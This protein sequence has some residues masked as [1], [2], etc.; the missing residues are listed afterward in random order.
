M[1]LSVRVLFDNIIF[2]SKFIKSY[3]FTLA[4]RSFKYL[5]ADYKANFEFPAI[6]VS[7]NEDHYTFGERPNVIQN[8]THAN[9]N[10]I[11]VLYDP[12]TQ[13]TVLIQE[14]HIQATMSIVINCE[15]QFQA[16]ECEFAC[17]RNLPVGKHISLFDFTS[18]LDIPT[19]YLSTLGIDYNRSEVVNLYTRMN[20]NTGI[21]GHCFSLN[22]KP[23]VRLDSAISTMSDT[24]Q[25]SFP[26]NI[27][28]MYSVQIPVWATADKGAP[29]IE[30][31]NIDFSR[32]GHEPIS[33]NSVRPLINNNTDK[34]GDSKRVI[35]RNLIVH[36]LEDYELNIV[37]GQDGN[38]TY[39]FGITFT[40]EDFIISPSFMFNIF[41]TNGEILQDV[42]PSLIDDNLNKVVFSWKQDEYEQHYN[43]SLT[44]PI[45]VQF[46]EDR[47]E[48]IKERGEN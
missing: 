41:D 5:K 30:R 18:F 48:L 23:F 3:E 26:V 42:T 2:P 7:L 46:V 15:S 21:I 13:I 14:E 44:N 47:S 45:I 27:E 22:Y 4:N 31:I 25:R 38:N 17:K 33:E 24:S 11:P 39:I 6:T 8:L 20:H 37:E 1:M 40:E 36:D 10:Q 32:F 19:T 12:D 35:R 16:K 34:Y 29:G 43:A 9:I 28:L